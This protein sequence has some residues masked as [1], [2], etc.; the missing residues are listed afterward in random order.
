VITAEKKAVSSE[1]AK[2][3]NSIH[4]FT[5]KIENVL[6]VMEFAG[7]LKRRKQSGNGADIKNW[8]LFER[9]H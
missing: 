6:N 8:R 5:L 4:S 9:K 2:R 1:R 3:G 7:I